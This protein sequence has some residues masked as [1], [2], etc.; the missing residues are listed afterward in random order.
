MIR[1]PTPAPN[2]RAS[3]RRPLARRAVLAGTAVACVAALLP[4][5]VFAASSDPAGFVRDLG[6]RV[7]EVLKR[8]DLDKAGKLAAL[9]ALLEEATDLDLIARLVLG[10]YWREATPEQRQ[11]YLELFRAL[12]RRAIAE[13]L[14]RYTG[15]TFEVTEGQPVDDRDTLVRTLVH[16]PEGGQPYVVDWRVRRSDGR[17]LV[18]DVVA[19]G[20]SLLLTQRSEVAEIAGQKGI[21]GLL[22]V[23][24][25]RLRQQQD[26]RS[27]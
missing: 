25:E 4:A 5:V 3:G 9:E 18:I 26:A 13:R 20:V 23:M 6:D 7:L 8:Q 12:L 19:E 16:R 24:E 1:P 27:G 14:D 15:Q 11:R 17:L 10:R 2:D 22:Q 21:D